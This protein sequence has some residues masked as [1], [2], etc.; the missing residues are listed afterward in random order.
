MH[1][2]L[3]VPM[4]LQVQHG[5]H[6]LFSKLHSRIEVISLLQGMNNIDGYKVT[7]SDPKELVESYKK[8][9]LV[10]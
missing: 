10:P 6:N 4:M 5:L 2:S 7:R 1:V 8:R 3:L 9:F